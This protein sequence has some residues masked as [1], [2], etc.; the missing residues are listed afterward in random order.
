MIVCCAV[1][2]KE[3]EEFPIGHSLHIA[4]WNLPGGRTAYVCSDV[5][6]ERVTQED[7]L[8]VTRRQ[9]RSLSRQQKTVHL[10]E[11]ILKTFERED[12]EGVYRSP[13]S[14]NEA[15]LIIYKIEALLRNAD[16]DYGEADFTWED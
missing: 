7:K 1:C 2:D 4:N 10:A 16:D 15:V 14:Y 8:A 5:C 13:S 3:F 9:L 11:N 6:K 12:G